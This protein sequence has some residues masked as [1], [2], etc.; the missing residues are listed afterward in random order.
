[1]LLDC[2]TWLSKKKK[3]MRVDPEPINGICSNSYD[4]RMQWRW[5]EKMVE[6]IV[7]L[8]TM[9]NYYYRWRETEVA[10][11]RSDLCKFFRKFLK[12]KTS[13]ASCAPSAWYVEKASTEVEEIGGK[14][15]KKALMYSPR[16]TSRCSGV[17]VRR[18]RCRNEARTNSKAILQVLSETYQDKKW[19]MLQINFL[20]KCGLVAKIS[21]TILVVASDPKCLEFCAANM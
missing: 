3:A 12:I 1:M 7:T 18:R 19:T 11:T 10:L 16:F 2:L 4:L 14:R 5:R 13:V 17:A 9:E 15:S 20:E 21:N 6:L 8:R